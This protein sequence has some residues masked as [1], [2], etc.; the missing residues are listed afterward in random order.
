M[1]QADDPIVTWVFADRDRHAVVNLLQPKEH[2]VP[3]LGKVP[4]DIVALVSLVVGGAILWATGGKGDLVGVGGLAVLFAVVWAPIRVVGIIGA[5][6]RRQHLMESPL[7]VILWRERVYMVGDRDNWQLKKTRLGSY[8][9]RAQVET[10][11]EIP[12]LRITYSYVSTRGSSQFQRKTN[13]VVVPVP[14]GKEDEAQR[15]V[16]LLMAAKMES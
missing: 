3:R 16:E 13:D 6:S 10:Q 7:E 1:S 4:V 5:A 9:Q 8:L 12:I 2:N 15:A 14:P 11:G